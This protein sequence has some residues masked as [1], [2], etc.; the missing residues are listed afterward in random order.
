MY[1]SR[2]SRNTT[3]RLSQSLASGIDKVEQQLI[4]WS[5]AG[6]SSAVTSLLASTECLPAK[7]AQPF[8]RWVPLGHLQSIGD[9]LSVLKPALYLL[10]PLSLINSFI[11]KRNDMHTTLLLQGGVRQ[12]RQRD[13]QV[14]TRIQPHDQE[15]RTQ[16]PPPSFL[17]FNHVTIR[18][19]Q[20][21]KSSI[22]KAT[23]GLGFHSEG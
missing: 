8:E 21:P 17:Q 22:S 9:A 11:K 19:V 7:K 14:L 5:T 16:S 20:T 12:G 6:S 3:A 10:E 4:K 23:H 18:L 15:Q 2:L 13:I 1:P